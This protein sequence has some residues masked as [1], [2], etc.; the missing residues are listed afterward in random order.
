M[1]GK[2]FLADMDT[3]ADLSFQEAFEARNDLY[4]SMKS[5]TNSRPDIRNIMLATN[6]GLTIYDRSFDAF[7]QSFLQNFPPAITG[8]DEEGLDYRKWLPTRYLDTPAR[9]DHYVITLRQK[10]IN[11]FSN[12]V[13]GMMVVSVR[14]NVLRDICMGSM[15]SDDPGDN[16]L[17]ILHP[18]GTIVSHW[19]ESL[20]G[21]S[22]LSILEQD[23]LDRLFAAAEGETLTATVGGSAML[24]NAEPIPAAGWLM[25]NA[26]SPAYLNREVAVFSGF[27]VIIAVVL[28]LVTLLA[29]SV[30]FRAVARSVQKIVSAMDSAGDS[31]FSVRVEMYGKNELRQIGD[32]FNYMMQTIR[33]LME[34]LRRQMDML[35]EATAKEKE[36]EIR[37]L[38]AQINPHFLYNTLDSINWMAIENNQL[39]ISDM[40]GSLAAL[41]RYNIRNSNQLVTIGEEHRHLEEYLSIQKSRFGGSFDYLFD[42][43][44]EVRRCYIHKLIFQPFIENA[45]LHAFSRTAHGGI[46][47][48][49]ARCHDEDHLLFYIHDNGAGMEQQAA[50]ALFG[51]GGETSG[52]GV[53]NA[54]SR[55][56]AYYGE[57]YSIRARSAPGQGVQL[58]IVIPK[59]TEIPEER[60]DTERE[61]PGG[62]GDAV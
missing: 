57:D 7:S 55:L 2:N 47:R 54:I 22:A 3:M 23:T 30:I 29:V 40:L 38:E 4:A 18:D 14:S 12:N 45:V 58:D 44:L 24:L 43:E 15:V 52:I 41:L 60:K 20:S 35:R 33:R 5:F 62:E 53:S 26:V 48:I 59:V 16:H 11:V 8:I 49:G 51:G 28:L 36:A 25:V 31:M 17:F 56:E 9:K 6:D 19:D 10:V 1:Y 13:Y 21:K 42:V 50:D 27:A 61:P 37:A 39:E 32:H 46:L 34:D